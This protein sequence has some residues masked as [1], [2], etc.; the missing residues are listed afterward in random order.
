VFDAFVCTL[1]RKAKIAYFHNNLTNQNVF[2]FKISTFINMLP[3][4]DT[5]LQHFNESITNLLQ[6]IDCFSFRDRST[7]FD[8]STQ[9]AAITE[10]LYQ[11]IV[12]GAFHHIEESNDI[13]AFECLQNCDFSEQCRLDILVLVD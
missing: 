10:L 11:I 6:Y 8:E 12:V 9:V 7:L 4:D 1:L 13:F 5:L 2:W 3:V